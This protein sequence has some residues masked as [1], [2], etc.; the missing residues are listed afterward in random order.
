MNI[1]KS[2][3]P[4]PS[5]KETIFNREISSSINSF[6]SAKGG[7]DN[8]NTAI[9]RERIDTNLSKTYILPEDSK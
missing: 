5:P 4:Y 8:N 1:V 7:N 6:K 9:N 2:D 3:N